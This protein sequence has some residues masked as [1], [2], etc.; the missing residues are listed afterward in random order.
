L[1]AIVDR[2]GIR[3]VL[4]IPLTETEVGLL[5]KSAEAVKALTLPWWEGR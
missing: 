4:P 2:S 1:P 5:R 3:R